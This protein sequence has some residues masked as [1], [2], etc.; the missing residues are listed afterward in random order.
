MKISPIKRQS[1]LEGTI[2]AIRNYIL[3][4]HLKVGDP[5]P[6]ETLLAEELGVSRNIMRE[7]MRHYRTLGIIK[8]KTKIGGVIA[9]LI[10][11]N[12][13]DGYL[14]FIAV[15]PGMMEKLAEIRRGLEVGFA[16]VMV[17]NATPEQIAELERLATKLTTIP[18][19]SSPEYFD[20]DVAFHTLLLRTP[21]NPILN[22]LIPFVIT[23]FSEHQKH[24]RERRYK[25]G[26]RN[27]DT[28][29][30][31]RNILEALKQRQPE[32]LR[33]LLYQHSQV[34]VGS[35]YKGTKK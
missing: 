13:Y 11:E 33:D 23:F 18:D 25:T 3:D 5:L 34:Y 21:G 35:L 10:P 8:T 7:A 16:E 1:T 30:A 12:P 14:P 27:F 17:A 32:K 19:Q 28:D 2:A 22:G 26:Q 15:N 6:S 24:Q 29:L 4:N 31:H 9:Q 20:T